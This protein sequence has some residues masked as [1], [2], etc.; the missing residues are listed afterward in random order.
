MSDAQPGRAA[1]TGQVRDAQRRAAAE[2]M[3]RSRELWRQGYIGIISLPIRREE[4]ATLVRYG[5]LD[6]NATDDPIGIAEAVGRLLD[7]TLAS[8]GREPSVRY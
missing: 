2:R 4:V 8:R 3:R 6:A 7:H 1:T 5:F